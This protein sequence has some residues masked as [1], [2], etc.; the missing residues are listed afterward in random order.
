MAVAA[1]VI[2]SIL[3]VAGAAGFFLLQNSS[4]SGSSTA[5]TLNSKTSPFSTSESSTS[6]SATQRS[7]AVASTRACSSAPF[8]S[9]LSEVPYALTFHRP[10]GASNWGI[11]VGGVHYLS[12]QTSL[13]LNCPDPTATYTYDTSFIQSNGT[14]YLCSLNCSGG[15]SLS[16]SLSRLHVEGNQVKDESGNV[17]ILKG[18]D[19]QEYGYAISYMTRYS[20]F[21]FKYLA[22]QWQAKI[23]RIPVAPTYWRGQHPGLAASNSTYYLNNI[24]EPTVQLA[25]KYGMYAIIDWHGEG[26][27]NTPGKDGNVNASLTNLNETMTFW[28]TISQH[29]NGRAGVIYEIFNEPGD[30]LTWNTWR[31]TA[32]A[33]V[34]EIRRYDNR[35]LILVGG[36]LW[37]SDL[38]GVVGDPV[39]GKNVAYVVHPYPITSADYKC[40]GNPAAWA[41]SKFLSCWDA[42]FGSAAAAYPVF[43]TEWGYYAT[44]EDSGCNAGYAK[45]WSGYETQLTTYLEAKGISWSPWSWS[46]VP[47]NGSCFSM[48]KAGSLFE[49][50]QFGQ[51]VRD[52]L[53]TLT[54]PASYIRG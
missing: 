27:V 37:A 46:P 10:V 40:G 30:T 9:T 25:N 42:S 7:T 21:H 47:G 13:T 44:D 35:T 6:L 12:N 2:A 34:D 54:R 41:P 36:T 43:A 45:Y 19:I 20:E 24:L 52:Q 8:N 22:H 28:S 18:V 1:L 50:T 4:S 23:I 39:N 5:S 16:S 33:L 14:R 17:L 3:V 11:T 15:L 32:Q 49:P 29:F 53:T 26:N 31:P 48:F 38:S 51:F